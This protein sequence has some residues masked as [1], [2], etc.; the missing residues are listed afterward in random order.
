[1]VKKINFDMDGTLCNFYGVK[2]WLR[3]LENSNTRPY[4]ICKPM[5]DVAKFTAAINALKRMGYIVN[6]ISYTS[7]T[8]S[9]KFNA[10]TEMVKKKWLAKNL[11]AL[12]F[13]NI[14]I[15]PYGTPKQEVVKD[16]ILFDDEEK[17]R[18]NWVGRSYRPEQIMEVL[19]NLL[20]E[21]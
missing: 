18:F 4:K 11:P 21:I 1:M 6:I 3:D 7:K 10:E 2:G 13:D 8:G 19:Q 16:G 14:H 9:A 5:V 12:E 17:N 15:V 20:L